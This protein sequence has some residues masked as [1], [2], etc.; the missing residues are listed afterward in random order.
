MQATH[1][2][3]LPRIGRPRKNPAGTK[4]ENFMLWPQHMEI[5]GQWMDA[6]GLSKS[7]ALRCIID[8]AVK[9]QGTRAKGAVRRIQKAS[10]AQTLAHLES[11]NTLDHEAERRAKRALAARKRRAAAR[12]S[13]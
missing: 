12:G 7:E 9:P 8:A 2:D 10:A 13:K 1:D 4:L 3:E 5:V 6:L 11:R